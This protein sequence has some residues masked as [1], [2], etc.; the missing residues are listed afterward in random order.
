MGVARVADFN[1]GRRFSGVV[2]SP[3]I[4]EAVEWAVSGI[5][6]RPLE[7]L[8]GRNQTTRNEREFEIQRSRDVLNRCQP[9]ICGA[10]FQI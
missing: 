10:P 6:P 9:R 1:A 5:R 3:F 7:S 2:R 4:V 8:H